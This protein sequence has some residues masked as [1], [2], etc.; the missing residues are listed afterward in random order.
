MSQNNIGLTVYPGMFMNFMEQ[1]PPQGWAVRNGATLP[2]A[3]QDYPE[4]WEELQKPENAWK[5]KTAAQYVALSQAAGGIGG[6]PFFVLD[7][8]AKTIRLPDTRGDYERA[9]QGGTM[10]NVGDWHGDAIRNIAG[11]SNWLFGYRKGQNSS[12]GAVHVVQESTDPF[13]MAWTAQNNVYVKLG[14]DA[15]RVV[16]TAAENRTRA[17]GL[18]P[19]VY[20]GGAAGTPVQPGGTGFRTWESDWFDASYSHAYSFT[21]DLGLTEPWRCF[22][23]L[24]V[25]IK[26]AQ[27]GWQPG[28]IIF[29]EGANYNG[30]TS[31]TEMGWAIGVAENG[32]HIT[33]GNNGSLGMPNKNGGFGYITYNNMECKLII[34]Y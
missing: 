28:D 2:N 14:I 27:Y 31:Y 32:A 19:C 1:T 9:A 8:T 17:I 30:N 10:T 11:N 4:L 18:L 13:C 6:A 24:V 7:E 3:D 34:H 16:P 23:H 21:H 15:S 22:P 5:L 12:K 29:G 26:E 25:R 33:F 20:V